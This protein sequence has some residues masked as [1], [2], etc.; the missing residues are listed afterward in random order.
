M[1]IYLD[2]RYIHSYCGTAVMI[3]WAMLL[4]VT[5]TTEK[6]PHVTSLQCSV[7]W[8]G[9]VKRVQHPGQL[10]YIDYKTATCCV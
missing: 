3:C 4:S 7:V 10:Y 2:R 6:L 1:W 8:K 9:H 5:L